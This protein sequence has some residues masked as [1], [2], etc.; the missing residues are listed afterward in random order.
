MR[1]IVFKMASWM[2]VIVL[3]ALF[4]YY[5][6]YGTRFDYLSAVRAGDA[7]QASELNIAVVWRDA[8]ESAFGRG[9]QLAAAEINAR[10]GVALGDEDGELAGRPINLVFFDERERAVNRH[11]ARI[12]Q[13]QPGLPIS[14]QI[15]EDTG[16]LAVIGHDRQ[17]AIPASVVYERSN[18]LFLSP[19]VTDRALTR[20]DFDFIFR[21]APL[22]QQVAQA[23]VAA[24][25][26]LIEV[27]QVRVAMLYP[28]VLAERSSAD[29]AEGL[30][31]QAEAIANERDER[32]SFEVVHAQPYQRGRR[33]HTEVVSSLL[34]ELGEVNIILIADVLP[35]AANVRRQL[36]DAYFARTGNDTL[37]MPV[38]NLS[39]LDWSREPGL[40]FDFG[41]DQ[42]DDFFERV[43]D[44]VLHASKVQTA[45]LLPRTP[46]G[47]RLSAALAT[48]IENGQRQHGS[49]LDLVMS[50]T[51]DPR[52]PDLGPIVA[53]TVEYPLE[54]VLVA[55]QGP[56]ALELIDRLR[57][58]GFDR[59]IICAPGLES[60]LLAREPMLP[61][62]WR[63]LASRLTLEEGPP[64]A[65]KQRSATQVLKTLRTRGYQGS[66][67]AVHRFVAESR[68]KTYVVSTFNP[69]SRSAEVQ[70]LVERFSLL[71]D[72]IDSRP[73]TEAALGYSAIVLLNHAFQ[74]ADSTDPQSVA[75]ALRL[76]VRVDGVL[77]KN[78][79]SPS[80]DL[81][82]LEFVLKH[83]GSDGALSVR[84]LGQASSAMPAPS[85]R[86]S[87]EPVY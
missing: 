84:P 76:F 35:D 82:G 49:Q 25:E 53:S 17:A 85:L 38:V 69:L 70:Q 55:G 27:K 16:I 9:A 56:A 1:R 3:V 87:V 19:T 2:F 59:P 29:V 8:Q 36:E 46:S 7:R 62:I 31:K 83:R 4:F 71:F 13:K 50:R 42:S 11:G 78:H 73:D 57:E 39:L 48:S 22:D 79:F 12:A 6:S 20:H 40:Y 81:M 43:A 26:Q 28:R 24:A 34:A 66:A 61:P 37:P 80:G 68:G 45:V 65:A 64:P 52:R 67:A 15:A 54:Y 30:R 23:M 77:G 44:L 41:P 74:R 58:A 60:L 75:E 10:G 47:R 51:Y 72:Q 18:V 86:P 32:L 21:M 14:R 63:A 33:D 5:R